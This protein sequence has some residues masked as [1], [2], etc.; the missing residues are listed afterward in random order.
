MTELPPDLSEPL[1]SDGDDSES[2]KGE[3]PV[4]KATGQTKRR[5][6]TVEASSASSP[7]R[8]IRAVAV[9]EIL[10]GLGAL[11]AA[12]ALWLWHSDLSAWLSDAVTLWRQYFGQL[13]ILQV[14]SLVD[15]ALKASEHWHIFVGL[16]I[17]YAS[18]RFIEAFGLWTDKTWAYWFSVLGYG[19][20]IPVELYY[21][22]VSPLDWFKIAI[23]VLN[24]IIVIVVYRN[25]KRK[26]LI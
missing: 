14:D 1:K 9:Y 26:G 15:K 20:F 24:I 7:S 5:K 2:T 23:F 22:F 13:L 6:I 4:P 8:S 12:T 11:L 18:L 17:G 19:I 25:M 3:G 10:K 21:L 16:I